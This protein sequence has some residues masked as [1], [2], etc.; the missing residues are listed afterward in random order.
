MNTKC[1]FKET[2]C[3]WLDKNSHDCDFSQHPPYF[4]SFAGEYI[5]D[6]RNRLEIEICNNSEV[7]L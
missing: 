7:S 1:P 4:C 5:S 3:N 6:I 2:N